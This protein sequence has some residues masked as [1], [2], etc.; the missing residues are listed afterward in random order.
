MLYGLSILADMGGTFWEPP[1]AS[2]VA[3]ELDNLFYGIF[4]I[5]V[6][7][8]LLIT[9]LLVVFAWKYR[10]RP[11]YIPPEA[12]K[13]NTALELTWTFIPTVIVTVI[14]V[15]GFQ[16]YM[17]LAV[18][19]PDPYQITV[20]AHMWAYSFFYPNQHIDNELHV[21][22][23]VPVEVIL[24]SSD[25]IHGFYI[26]AFRVKKDDVP[27]RDNRIWFKAVI[28][29]TYDVYCT[30]YC[31]QGHS[32]MRAKVYV[33]P[34]DEYKKWLDTA[35]K[36]VGTPAEH[37]KYLWQTRGCNA[38]HSIDGT[39]NRCPT[40]KDLFGSPVHLQDGSAV[41]ADETYLRY[42][43]EHPNSKPVVGFDKIMP[44]TVDAGLITENDIGD[45]ILYL[46]TISVNYHGGNLP[47]TAP[48]PAATHVGGS[49][50]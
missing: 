4:W 31:G 24:N 34:L 2:S 11:D 33:Q 47:A 45:I 6:F 50:K 27:G 17:D 42:V 7:F 12:P 35:S 49:A 18:P 14:F 44:P 28:P 5:T 37:G 22:L 23:D 15:Y 10:Y 48:S 41:T 3:P 16:R 9:V 29:G 32:T 21:P 39:S 19:P 30:Q 26:P 36:F 1:Q 38:C 46:K 20:Q 43:I 25:V 40:W 8:T 13:H